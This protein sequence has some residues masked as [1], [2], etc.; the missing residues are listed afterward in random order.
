MMN[1]LKHREIRML[2]EEPGGRGEV[3]A[4]LGGERKQKGRP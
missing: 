4:T 3:L 1:S 2:Q